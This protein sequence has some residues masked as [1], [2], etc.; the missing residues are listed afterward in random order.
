M[1][2]NI[3]CSYFLNRVGLSAL[4]V[5]CFKFFIFA[6]SFLFLSNTIY[7]CFYFENMQRR[8]HIEDDAIVAVCT[9]FKISDMYIMFIDT[10]P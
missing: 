4:L 2:V 7:T 1:F 3:F 9:Q 8:G 5:R 10:V 6:L